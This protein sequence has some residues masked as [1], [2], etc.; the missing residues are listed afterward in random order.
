M[1]IS[2][3]LLHTPASPA[4]KGYRGLIS[5]LEQYVCCSS[6]GPLSPRI[7]RRLFELLATESRSSRQ[8]ASPDLQVRRGTD[9]EFCCYSACITPATQS[10]SPPATDQ[11]LDELAFAHPAAQQWAFRGRLRA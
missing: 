5:S 8:Q 2:L 4:S 6:T 9:T 1:P 10:P 11:H 7:A 3:R